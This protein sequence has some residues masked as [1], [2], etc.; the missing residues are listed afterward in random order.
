MSKS[1]KT[2]SA[3]N[4]TVLLQHVA[5]INVTNKIIGASV[6][7]YAAKYA[8]KNVVELL[9]EKGISANVK[10]LDNKTPLLWACQ[11]SN[12]VNNAS[13]RLQHGA[14]INIVNRKYGAGVLHYGAQFADT[15]MIEFLLNKSISVNI[16]DNDNETPLLWACQAKNQV[17]NVAKLLQH[18]TDINAVSKEH[19]ANALHN[20]AKFSDK[21]LIEFLLSAGIS[22]NVVDNNNNTPLMWACQD[23][24]NTGNLKVLFE[25]GA[26][27]GMVDTIRGAGALHY[28]AKFCDK[29]TIVFLLEKSFC[30]N[31]ADN[32]NKTPLLWAY[33]SE[34][35]VE[36]VETL[37]RYGARHN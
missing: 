32:D 22:V 21:G 12:N 31:V 33:Q 6:L 15:K 23:A 5:S 9:L 36:N 16:K 27:V 7:H 37:F 24:N 29:N 35:I 25:H 13:L 2:D 1:E 17:Q 34:N 19:G 20:A 3:E 10:N 18:G 28:A 30:V 26:D 11:A 8:D 4:I 14:D